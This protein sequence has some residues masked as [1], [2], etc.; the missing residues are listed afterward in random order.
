MNQ[1]DCMWTS[2]EDNFRVRIQMLQDAMPEWS[3]E[4]CEAI[5]ESPEATAVIIVAR[6]R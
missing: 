4:D 5:A 2:L 1:E 3:L 6:S